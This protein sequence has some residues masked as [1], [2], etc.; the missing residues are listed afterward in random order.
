MEDK[1]NLLLPYPLLPGGWSFDSQRRIHYTWGDWTSSCSR[2]PASP[3]HR[4]W[5]LWYPA[6]TVPSLLRQTVMF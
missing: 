4:T 2:G 5:Q 3:H 6:F 1:I